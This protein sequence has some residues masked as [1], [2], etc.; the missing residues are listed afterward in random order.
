MRRQ[1]RQGWWVGCPGPRGGAG[2]Q[3]RTGSAPERLQLL[4]ALSRQRCTERGQLGYS[5]ETSGL[6]SGRDHREQTLT[7]SVVTVGEGRGNQRTLWSRN[8]FS[9]GTKY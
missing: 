4:P 6:K 3:R 7:L 2:G 8:K 9:D 1:Y 5:Q